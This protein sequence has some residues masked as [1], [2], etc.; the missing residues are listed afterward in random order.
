MVFGS[1][2]QRNLLP[3]VTPEQAMDHAADVL[4]G[5]L[6][7][8]ADLGVTLCLEP[9]AP[10]ETD[11][12]QTCAEAVALIDRV[13]H[14]N[15]SL[16]LDVKAM[17]SEA[18][19]VPETIRRYGPR[20][21]HFHA[22]DANLQGPGFGDVDF[23]PIFQALKDTDYTGWVSVEVFDFAPGP[24]RLARESIDYMRRCEEAIA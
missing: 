11:F 20:A 3:G 24:E 19:P 6:P 14:S 18:A 17:S 23:I 10:T 13:D 21:G 1:P 16:H 12:M 2:Q 5:A 9:L 15:L 7:A 4:R 8:L 22:N